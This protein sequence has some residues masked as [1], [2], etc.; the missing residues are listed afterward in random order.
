MRESLIAFGPF[1]LDGYRRTLFRGQQKLRI[2]A[3]P[4]EVLIVLVEN[5]GRTVSKQ[6]L[7]DAVWKD[8]FVTEDNLTQAILKIRRALGDERDNPQYLQTI[9]RVGYRFVGQVTAPQSPSAELPSRVEAAPG[10]KGRSAL[11]WTTAVLTLAL[12]GAA[13]VWLTRDILELP[14]SRA[15]QES[16]TLDPPTQVPLPVRSAAKPA[17]APDGHHFLFV[18]YRKERPGVGDLYVAS[19]T[20]PG[21][22]RIT[23]GL[24]P[25]G[26]HPVF[27]PD[28][29]EIVFARWRSGDDGTRWPDL[30]L[31]PAVGGSARILIEQASGAGFSPDGTSLAYTK[32]LPSGRPLWMSPRA[33]LGEHR[34]LAPFGFTPRWSPDGRSIAFTTSNPEGGVGD[35]WIASTDL[36]RSRKLTSLPAQIYGIAWMRDGRSL[37]FASSRSGHYHLWTI[38]V[39]GGQP[40]ALTQG[41][42]GYTSPSAS[43]DGR[44]LLFTH[45]IPSR[46]LFHAVTDEPGPP[47]EVDRAK[48]HLWPACSP[49]G[50][51]VASVI[52]EPGSGEMLY[53]TDVVKG[54]ST[55]VG[56][57]GAWH[58][59]WVDNDQVAYLCRDAAGGT[60]V[61]V[62]P[63]SG[64]ANRTW[65]RFPEPASWLAVHPSRRSLAVVLDR[66]TQGRR[67]V[68]RD[69]DARQDLA[70]A[71]GGEYE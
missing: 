26:D 66:A 13:A 62:A 58:P 22:E 32:H 40:A 24:D 18:G 69:L 41:V 23:E 31:A 63:V 44:A 25:R 53:V 14:A 21:A 15:R 2:T 28:G 39:E 9:P 10:R 29:T 51:R 11:W 8:T 5:R 38:S 1:T 55:R 42:G 3:K 19:L 7:M 37:V 20:R 46:S 65:C 12:V 47:T 17:F 4:L 16:A 71:E 67:V 49:G 34:E 54:V 43:P 64:G 52:R 48:Y 57:R 56:D 60:E 61:R 36:A 27:G 59:A 45:V 68:V 33:N 6:E 35:L 30:W 50:D 70:L